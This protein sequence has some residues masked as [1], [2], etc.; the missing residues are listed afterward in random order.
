M[1]EREAERER[2]KRR[3]RES[4]EEMGG[5]IKRGLSSAG[6]DS[7]NAHNSQ[8]GKVKTRSLEFHPGFGHGN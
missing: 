2:E 3:E 7:S 6:S 4:K 8:L 1:R 5:R